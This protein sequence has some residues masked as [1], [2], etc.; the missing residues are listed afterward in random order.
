M[1]DF[2]S[3]RRLLRSIPPESQSRPSLSDDGDELS[4]S[5]GILLSVVLGAAVWGVLL[6]LVA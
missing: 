5:R 6:Y 2:I 3:P 4:P 1:N